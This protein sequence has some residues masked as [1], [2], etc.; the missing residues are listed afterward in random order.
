MSP[1]IDVL[2]ALFR[3]SRRR[4]SPTLESLVTRLSSDESTV[5]R[6]LFTLAKT[7]LIQ[8]TP[9]GLRLT[10]EGLAVA[11]A[12]GK[13]PKP[14]VKNEPAPSPSAVVPPVVRRRRAA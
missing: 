9:A 4:K 14:I 5:R 11:V 2:R 1:E 7:G 13:R 10:L 8:R 12:A 6:A 3:F